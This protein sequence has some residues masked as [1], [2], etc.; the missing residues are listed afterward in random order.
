MRVPMERLLT[1]KALA[2]DAV[3]AGIAQLEIDPAEAG[4]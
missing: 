4:A 1:G 3:V 2:A